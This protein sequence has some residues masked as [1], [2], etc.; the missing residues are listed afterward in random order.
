M[1]L[2]ALVHVYDVSGVP[3]NHVNPFED[4]TSAMIL[5]HVDVDDVWTGTAAWCSVA[6]TTAAHT[7]P[8]KTSKHCSSRET[9]DE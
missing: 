7:L 8:P 1:S 3:G 9:R 6:A 4:S 2:S 5:D